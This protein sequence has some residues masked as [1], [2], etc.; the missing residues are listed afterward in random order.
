[1]KLIPNWSVTY[2][3]PSDLN[4]YNRQTVV[5]RPLQLRRYTDSSLSLDNNLKT[6]KHFRCMLQYFCGV[7]AFIVDPNNVPK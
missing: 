7:K 1:M 6:I 2:L 3:C 5:L 4:L